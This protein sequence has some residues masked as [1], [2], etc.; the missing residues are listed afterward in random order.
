MRCAGRTKLCQCMAASVV[1][2]PMPTSF[3]HSQNNCQSGRMTESLAND[4]ARGGAAILDD[5]RYSSTDLGV[6]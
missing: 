1:E 6:L 2:Q 3:P 4:G 5:A